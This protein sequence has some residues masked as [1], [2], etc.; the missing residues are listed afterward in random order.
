[1]TKTRR[2]LPPPSPAEH[3]LLI[4]SPEARAER[5][6]QRIGLYAIGLGR[7][8]KRNYYDGEGHL[9]FPD[10]LPSKEA[11]TELGRYLRG[12]HPL[13]DQF[14]DHHKAGPHPGDIDR[15]CWAANKSLDERFKNEHDP[16]LREEIRR[17][18]QRQSVS[19]GDK[20]QQAQFNNRNAALLRREAI[21]TVQFQIAQGQPLDEGAIQRTADAVEDFGFCVSHTKQIGRDLDD[22]DLG[23]KIARVGFGGLD[24]PDLLTANPDILRLVRIEQ[25]ARLDKWGKL[26]EANQEYL[27]DRLTENGQTAL[28][29]VTMEVER[30]SGLRQ[31]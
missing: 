30:L 2:R 7:G 20:L 4:S 19:I 28:S 3:E 10:E 18:M 13:F 11:I 29:N 23:Y 24:N 1:M 9:P 14:T 25:T 21:A 6:A 8:K 26:F 17:A 16:K 31:Q 12:R 5:H 22:E 27:G 15:Y